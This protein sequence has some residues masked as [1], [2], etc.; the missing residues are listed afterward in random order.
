MSNKPQTH[1]FCKVCKEWKHNSEMIAVDVC[2]KCFETHDKYGNVR[3]GLTPEAARP[4]EELQDI[5]A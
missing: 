3:R 4:G 5:S 1:S 2:E